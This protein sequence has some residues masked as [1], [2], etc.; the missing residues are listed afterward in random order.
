MARPTVFLHKVA[1]TVKEILALV[2]GLRIGVMGSEFVPFK[3]DG[4]RGE[5]PSTYGIIQCA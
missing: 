3:V 2:P 4:T 1:D 5:F